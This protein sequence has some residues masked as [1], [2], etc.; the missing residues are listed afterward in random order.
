MRLNI[1]GS[2]RRERG[3]KSR[4]QRRPF[5]TRECYQGTRMHDVRAILEEV[6]SERAALFAV[7]E[8]G[9]MSLLYAATYPE[10]TSAPILYG[11]C[12]ERSWAPD[13]PLGWDD[14]Q[15][16]RFLENIER[17]WGT[18][19][20]ICIEM[21]APSLARDPSAA[22][23]LASCFR[24]AASPGAA[25]AI[26]KMNRE[27]DVRHVLPAIRAPCA[28]TTVMRFSASRQV[29]TPCGSEGH[30]ARSRT[31]GIGRDAGRTR[32]HGPGRRSRVKSTI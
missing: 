7:S 3:P 21:W 16:Q 31:V 18:L 14:E 10:R 32:G 29:L 11:S 28:S 9:P 4:R 8:G 2:T 6:G 22:E 25:A 5:S 17:N 1:S 19:Q 20:G 26:M 13:Y 30:C 12:A 23:R 15:W 27:I 24:T